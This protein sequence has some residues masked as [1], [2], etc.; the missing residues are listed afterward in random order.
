[1]IFICKQIQN[2]VEAMLDDRPAVQ[3]QLMDCLGKH[4]TFP[5]EV[6][7]AVDSVQLQVRDLLVRN[8]SETMAEQC[9]VEPVD[10]QDSRLQD[11]NQSKA[12][13]LLGPVCG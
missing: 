5:D 11:S 7:L 13:E 6:Q 4:N 3:Q 10:A 1:M 12:A 8:K 2:V 9:S